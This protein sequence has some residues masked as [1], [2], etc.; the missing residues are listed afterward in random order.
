MWR[1][2]LGVLLGLS[3][4]ITLITLLQAVGHKLW[5]LPGDFAPGDREAIAEAVRNAP[6]GA[7]LWVALAWFAG[8]FAGG[9]AALRVA[10]DTVAT[11]PAITVEAVLLTFGALTLLSFPHPGWFWIVGL[12][13]F[14]LGAFAAVRLARR[15]TRSTAA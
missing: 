12:L 3:V 6:A 14:P 10:R 9:Y 15:V 4:A 2:V 5:P 8:T 1:K 7:L 11:W 13:S